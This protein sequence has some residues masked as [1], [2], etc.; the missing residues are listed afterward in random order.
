MYKRDAEMV[1]VE[2]DG[3]GSSKIDFFTPG[4]VLGSSY[5]DLTPAATYDYFSL[6][7]W[8]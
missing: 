3:A 4:R 8:V 2:F 7:G 1:W 5:S 6:E